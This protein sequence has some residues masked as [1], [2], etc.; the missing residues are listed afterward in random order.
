[1]TCL[2]SLQPWSV[3]RS[4][5][6]VDCT[7]VIEKLAEYLDAEARIELC[8]AIEEHL[9]QCHNCRIEVDTVK[10][11]IVLYQSDREIETPVT[12]SSRLEAVL[13]QEYKRDP[14]RRPSD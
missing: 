11:T 2:S 1:M 13:A 14:D 9:S 6:S 10:K 4:V 8:R 3:I 12:V 7:E 5:M